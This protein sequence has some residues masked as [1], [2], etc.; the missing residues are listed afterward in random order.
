MNITADFSGKKR[1]GNFPAIT[2]E[3]FMQ[4]SIQDRVSLFAH[5][6]VQDTSYGETFFFYISCG[7]PEY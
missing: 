1:A 3:H 4:L 5:S 2:G 7:L 6:F